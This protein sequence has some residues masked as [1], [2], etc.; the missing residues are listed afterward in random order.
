[1]SSMAL[2]GVKKLDP[3]SFIKTCH[4]ILDQIQINLEKQCKNQ[5]ILNINYKYK[6]Y[7]RQILILKPTQF[8]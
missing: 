7:Y 6:P 3:W 4:V 5:Q 1:M 8:H 2:K